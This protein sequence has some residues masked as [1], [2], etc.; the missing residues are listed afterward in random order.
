MTIET[1]SW[2]FSQ[3]FITRTRSAAKA[4]S[5]HPQGFVRNI[6]LSIAMPLRM[7]ATN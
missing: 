5:A 3:L 6:P 2:N 4:R 1:T 7:A